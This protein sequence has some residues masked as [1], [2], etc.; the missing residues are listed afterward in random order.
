M[1]LVACLL[2]STELPYQ[3]TPCPVP[4]SAKPIR[5]FTE[6]RGAGNTKIEHSR[7]SSTC[8]SFGQEY[9]EYRIYLCIHDM[10]IYLDNRVYQS[11]KKE[12]PSINCQWTD[13]G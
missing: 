5:V 7:T 9:Y 13:V 2:S 8:Q 11:I 10:Y 3:H 1:L 12:N 4:D 6:V